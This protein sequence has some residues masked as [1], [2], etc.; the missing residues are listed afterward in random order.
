MR[1]KGFSKA[2]LHEH[3][4]TLTAYQGDKQSALCIS[5]PVMLNGLSLPFINF[6]WSRWV[7][8]VRLREACLAWLGESWS[9]SHHECGSICSECTENGRFILHTVNAAW[10]CSR[11]PD[12]LRW[13]CCTALCCIWAANM[14]ETEGSFQQIISAAQ[15]SRKYSGRINAL[16]IE[17]ICCYWQEDDDGSSTPVQRF[18]LSRASVTFPKATRSHR[19]HKN[20]NLIP[21]IK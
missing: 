14:E 10:L 20:K 12:N 19:K 2:D 21:F 11:K 6:I 13:L 16:I 5:R 15:L 18:W 8:C 3:C 7:R 1:N 9:I 17:W 4:W